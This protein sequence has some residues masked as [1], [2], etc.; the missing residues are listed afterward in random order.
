[1]RCWAGR[2][3]A[4]SRENAFSSLLE[5]SHHPTHTQATGVPT[6]SLRLP[7]FAVFA[8]PSF[9]SLHPYTNHYTARANHGRR[10]PTPAASPIEGNCG[11]HRQDCQVGMLRIECGTFSGLVLLVLEGEWRKDE[12][13]HA[14][15]MPCCRLV[16]RQAES[17]WRVL[18]C[19]LIPALFGP[20]L[21]RHHPPCSLHL[22]LPAMLPFP[23]QT[24]VPSKGDLSL[25]F[26]LLS[27]PAQLHHPHAHTL[28][29]LPPSLPPLPP[30]LPPTRTPSTRGSTCLWETT[31]SSSALIPTSNSS[32]IWCFP[33]R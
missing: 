25:P 10:T 5:A 14:L 17:G 27:T 22:S 3:G 33:S 31:A 1:M 23:T 9:I 20:D 6:I 13:R 26:L 24:Q 30:S 19:G 21:E 15:G 8:K 4:A 28:P 18:L 16:D 2:A 32:C 7:A 29:S 12:G 11:H